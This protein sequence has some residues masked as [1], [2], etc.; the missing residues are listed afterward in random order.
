[1]SSYLRVRVNFLGGYY[2]GEEWPPAPMRLMQAIVAGS[3]HAGSLD[4]N[5]TTLSWLE[6]LEPPTIHAP[7]VS[8]GKVFTAYV[9]RN[10]DDIT[11]RDLYRG[12]PPYEASSRRRARYDAQATQRRWVDS[13]VTY[14]W[15]INDTAKA[16]HLGVLSR[17]MVCL[18]RAE[19]LAFAS[20]QLSE[21]PLESDSNKWQPSL[22]TSFMRNPLRVPAEGSLSSLELR[23]QARRHRI[24]S[25]DFVDP[26]VTYS[27]RSYDLDTTTSLRP[28]LLYDLHGMDPGSWLS[29][30]HN[31]GV[32]VAAMIRHALG[33]RVSQQSLGYATGHVAGDDL[34]DRLS[35]IPLPSIG[36]KNV[37]GRIRRAMVLGP[38]GETFDSHRFREIRHALAHTPLVQHGTQV[39]TMDQTDE[40]DG[41]AQAYL[42]ASNRWHTVTPLV[43]HGKTTRGGK[44]KGKFDRHKAEKLILHALAKAGLPQPVSLRFQAAPY[45]RSGRAAREYRVPQHLS[46]FSRFHVSVTFS[47]PVAGPMLAGVGRHYGLGLFVR[48]SSTT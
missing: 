14:E 34:D 4:R 36:N 42:K 47:E 45:E 8:V 18:G 46:G 40:I 35:W 30:R 43:T 32:T 6:Q 17:E 38:E 5:T 10:S 23:E 48:G 20:F 15:H 21:T 22:G 37:D 9:P 24:E 33:Q 12:T 25:K 26:P 28:F 3:A 19:D 27:E 31:E 16:E 1:M 11:L 44:Q 29:W 7:R 39:G 41:V 2:H 13:P